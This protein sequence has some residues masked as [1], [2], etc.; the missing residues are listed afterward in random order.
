MSDQYNMAVDVL[1]GR[2]PGRVAMLWADHRGARASLTWAELAASTNRFGALLRDRGT[3]RGDRVALVL[4][5]LPETAAAALGAL[6]IGA[7]LVVMSAL[8]QRD[9]IAYRLRDCTARVVI[10]D[11]DHESVVRAAVA[12]AGTGTTVVVLAPELLDGLPEDTDPVPTHADDPALISYTSGTTGPAKGI[13]HAHRRLLGHNEFEVCH[14]LQPSEV[15]HGAG[16]WA[17]SLMKLFGPWRVGA[18]QFVYQ[19]GPRFDP[20][21]LFTAMAAHDVTNTLLNPG[22]V[23]RLRQADPEAGAQIPLR[24]RIACCSSE[25]LPAD[26]LTWFQDQFGVTLLDYIL[27]PARGQ[28]GDVRR[29]LVAHQRSGPYRRGRLLVVPRPRRRRHHLLRVPHRPLRR[30]ERAGRP[31]RGERLGGRRGA[32]RRAGPGRVRLRSTG[33]RCRHRPTVDR[34]SAGPCPRAVRAVRLPAPDRVR[35]VAS[36]L[37]HQQNPT[38]RAAPPAHR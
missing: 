9:A 10:T 12:A 22:V 23:R 28:R 32:G 33:R 13:V 19:Q 26:L 27:E 29:D 31:P 3:G 11:Q 1:T 4:P 18:V 35:P 37:H 7:I 14:D 25:P 6:R 34:R 38:G 36:D 21:A 17:W 8:W 15:F 24:L 30:R 5:A 16:D 20:V 2:E